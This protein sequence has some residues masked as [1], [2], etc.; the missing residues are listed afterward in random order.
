MGVSVREVVDLGRG[1][2]CPPAPVH[3]SWGVGL[4]ALGLG[5][6]PGLPVLRC[7]PGTP[8]TPVLLAPQ[9]HITGTV[10]HAEPRALHTSPRWTSLAGRCWG[11]NPTR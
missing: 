3:L 8:L 10:S 9:P 6:T 2:V 7:S 11:L 1:G 5:S 4:P